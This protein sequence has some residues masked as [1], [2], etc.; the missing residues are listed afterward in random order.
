MDVSHRFQ[1]Q[2]I[3]AFSLN[4]YFVFTTPPLFDAPSRGTPCSMNIIYTPLES[5]FNGL[6][7]S[8]GQYG[9]VY[10][11]L[12]VVGSQICEIP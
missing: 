6:Q 7:F 8:P 2:D 9:S 5:T 12:T 1:L 10:I 3:D 11:C 4:I